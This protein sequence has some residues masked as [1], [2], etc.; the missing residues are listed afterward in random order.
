[1]VV[2][3]RLQIAKVIVGQKLISYCQF[4]PKMK[5]LYVGRRCGLSLVKVRDYA[6]IFVL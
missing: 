1:M 4:K 3:I 6:L 5:P 2:A